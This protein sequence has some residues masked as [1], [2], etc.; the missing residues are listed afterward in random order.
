[1]I[2]LIALDLDGTTLNYEGRLEDRTK[3]I[4]EAAIAKGVIIVIATGRVFSAIPKEILEI[5]GIHYAI[6][7]NGANLIDLNTRQ[8]IYS[9]LMNQIT[10]ENIF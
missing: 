6:T 4:L 3:V 1:M 8:L 10:V 2:K 5:S 7:S 9:N